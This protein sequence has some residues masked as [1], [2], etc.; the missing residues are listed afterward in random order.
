VDKL[1]ALKE[2]IAHSIDEMV[3]EHK[4]PV[5]YGEDGNLT[6]E[7][8]TV[9][10]CSELKGIMEIMKQFV[11]LAFRLDMALQKFGLSFWE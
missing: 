6:G 8:A 9:A 5:Y 11:E 7:G 2:Y 1:R 3:M 4:A 10:V